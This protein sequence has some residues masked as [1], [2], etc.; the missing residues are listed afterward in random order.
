MTIV[1]PLGQGTPSV[2]AIERTVA[3]AASPVTLAEAKAHCRVLHDD[4]DAYIQAL[5]DAAIDLV[6]GE[7]MLGRAMLTQTWAQW[8]PQSPG[9]VRLSMGPFR[10][11]TG[12]HYYNAEA[13]LT[14]ATLSDFD[15]H[16]QGDVVTVGPKDGFSWPGT[17]VRPDAI[18]ITYTAG[19][20][21]AAGDVP[22][23]IRNALLMLVGH[24]YANREAVTDATMR[25]L[26]MAVEA[27]IGRHRVGWYG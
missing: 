27:L 8:V 19:F 14:E 2:T 16:K 13:V 17:Q 4:E 20:G 3:P 23:G 7:G 1:W 24:W 5:I 11:L 12:V 10:S 25:D 22:Q 26:P 9:R 18:R 21:D 6:D 15:V